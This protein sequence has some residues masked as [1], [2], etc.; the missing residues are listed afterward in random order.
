MIVKAY[1]GIPLYGDSKY[2][3]KKC[4]QEEIEQVTFVNS[5]RAQYPDSYGLIL[6]HPENEGKL[7]NGQFTRITRSRA[8]GMTKG[9]ADIIVPGMPSFVCEIKRQDRTLSDLSQEQYDYLKAACSAGSFVC[10]A[11]GHEAAENAFR[12][13]LKLQVK[14]PHHF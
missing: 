7:I 9:A 2:R 10:I 8:M 5:I 13:W 12:D 4:P 14:N 6:V 3:N 1:P 11:L